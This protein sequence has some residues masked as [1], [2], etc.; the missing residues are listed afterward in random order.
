LGQHLR[1]APQLLSEASI[2]WIT[3]RRHHGQS[4]TVARHEAF[5]QV[6]FTGMGEACIFRNGLDTGHRMML[7]YDAL[8]AFDERSLLIELCH[9][10]IDRLRSMSA[11]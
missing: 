4:I 8:S 6:I 3:V 2:S 9:A 5:F 1:P 7:Q 11:L 10:T